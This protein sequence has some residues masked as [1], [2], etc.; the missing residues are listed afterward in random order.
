MLFI[1]ATL[2]LGCI[3]TKRR[4]MISFPDIGFP[5]IP[6]LPDLG[7]VDFGECLIKA[8]GGDA[9]LCA[10]YGVLDAFRGCALPPSLGGGECRFKIDETNTDPPRPCV[11][12][13]AKWDREEV[14]TFLEAEGQAKDLE[15]VGSASVEARAFGSI[16]MGTSVGL[17][18]W[19]RGNPQMILTLTPPELK[20]VTEI[21]LTAKASSSFGYKPE[22]FYISKEKNV[23]TRTFVV[24]FVPISVDVYAQAYADIEVSGSADSI[25]EIKYTIDGIVTFT[26]D[27]LDIT[28]DFN[29]GTLKPINNKFSPQLDIED[30]WTYVLEAAANMLVTVSVGVELE[31][32]INHALSLW[33]SSSVSGTASIVGALSPTSDECVLSID[34]GITINALMDAKFGLTDTE[35]PGQFDFFDSSAEVCKSFL[36][37]K[38]ECKADLCDDFMG[39]VKKVSPW[40]GII[41]LPPT[42]VEIPIINVEILKKDLLDICLKAD[43]FVGC[44]SSFIGQPCVKEIESCTQCP[45]DYPD[46]CNCGVCGSFGSCTW[47]CEVGHSWWALHN[48]PAGNECKREDPTCSACPANMPDQ[49]NCG[50]CGSFGGCST[51]CQKHHEFFL[52]TRSP[53]GFPCEK[54]SKQTLTYSLSVESQ[55]LEHA[56]PVVTIL[57]IVG[58]FGVARVFWVYGRRTAKYEAIQETI[59]I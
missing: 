44:L 33:L 20:L 1:F 21:S 50:I 3:A 13:I 46:E 31:V 29:T 2:M 30:E 34:S 54:V 39:A 4:E 43:E 47:T 26:E 40:D 18:I 8:L 16:E 9:A 19:F 35:I 58:V 59:E 56:H 17:D 45:S 27:D 7:I 57:A 51:S 22:R 55:H 11:G 14:Q 25:A 53:G 6:D 28:I 38:N 37:R 52:L 49:C 5:D 23:L 12:V 48:R 42:A 10:A 24:G 32:R 41:P 15:L 36:G